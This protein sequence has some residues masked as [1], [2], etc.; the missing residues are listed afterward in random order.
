MAQKPLDPAVAL[1]ALQAVRDAGGIQSRA[2]EALGIPRGTLQARLAIAARSGLAL[3]PLPPAPVIPDDPSE[4]EDEGPVHSTLFDERW[5]KF[6]KWI[7]RSQSGSSCTRIGNADRRVI[8]Q[9]TDWHEPFINEKAFE[10]AVDANPDADVAVI[11][12]DPMN[13]CAFSRFIESTHVTPQDEF[14]RLTRRFQFMASRYPQVLCNLGNHVDRLRKY[15]GK[16]VDP[17][18]M[19]LVKTD[20]VHFIV[21]GLRREGVTNISVAQPM[22]D[23]LGSSNWGLMV[24]DC[25]FTHGETHGALSTKPAENVAKWMRRW[26]RHLPMRPRV[27]VQEHNHRGGMYYD[28]ELQALLIMAPCLSQDVEYQV[29]ADLKYRPNQ[30]GYTRIV[31][32]GEGHTLINESRFYLLDEHGKERA[33]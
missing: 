26:E 32:N 30:L 28:D 2:A 14:E 21:E 17:W 16:R 9:T 4:P 18:A 19:F 8:F 10:A 12:G 29:T 3:E 20:P 7:G 11:G 15:F 22:I 31:Q 27:I 13:A 25:A 24:G 1:A 33:A 5:E 6:N 23:G